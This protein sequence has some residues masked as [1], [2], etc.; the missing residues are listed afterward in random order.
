MDVMSA[1]PTSTTHY[2][3]NSPGAAC[4]QPR[5]AKANGSRLVWLLLAVVI[6]ATACSPP[7]TEAIAAG[8]LEELSSVDEL[9]TAFN[10]DTGTP[11]LLLLLSPT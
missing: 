1:R 7:I 9:A 8:E 3:R 2:S 10:A 11:R 5:M 6:L 4:V